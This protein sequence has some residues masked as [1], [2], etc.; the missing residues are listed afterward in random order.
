MKNCQQK[1]QRLDHFSKCFTIVQRFSENSCSRMNTAE[2]Y[3]T[4]SSRELTT[5][6]DKNGLCGCYITMKRHCSDL[7]KYAVVSGQGKERNV[8]LSSHFPHQVLL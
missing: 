1:L 5:P 4:C 7:A 3:E 6:F 2:V 8:A